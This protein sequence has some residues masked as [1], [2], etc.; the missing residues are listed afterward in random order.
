[1]NLRPVNAYFWMVKFYE[2][3]IVIRKCIDKQGFMSIN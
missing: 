1:M 2:L 3:L